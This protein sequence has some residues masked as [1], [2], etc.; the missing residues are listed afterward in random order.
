MPE[1]T[2]VET[3]NGTYKV[4]VGDGPGR[5]THTVSVSADWADDLGCGDVPG[6]DLVRASFVFLLDREPATSILRNFSLEQI[7]QYFTEYPKSISRTLGTAY[8]E[9]RPGTS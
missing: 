1:V 2:V 7:A 6:I 5:T 8:P 3:G 4:V 9:R